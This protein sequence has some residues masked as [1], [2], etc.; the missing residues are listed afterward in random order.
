MKKLFSFC[1]LCL[2]AVSAM[3]QSNYVDLGLPSGT[4]WKKTNEGGDSTLYTYNEAVSRFGN[5]LPTNQQLE[6]LKNKCTWTWTGSGYKVI[7]PNGE[8]ITLPAAGLHRCTGD[9]YRVGT[10]GYYWSSTPFD[11]DYVCFLYFNLSEVDM[12]KDDRCAGLSVRL[13]K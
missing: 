6:E 2:F 10:V 9:V 4:L 11:S 3:A 1:L 7:G 8:S 12:L 13:V 5:K